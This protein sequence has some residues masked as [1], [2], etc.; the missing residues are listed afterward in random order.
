M[1]HWNYRIIETGSG[2][3]EI[4]EV[5]Y[6]EDGT[7][8]AISEEAEGVSGESLED[9][10][11]GLDYVSKAMNAPILKESEIVFVDP[12]GRNE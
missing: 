2:M 4:R 9:L 11:L 10:K 8:F 3:F 1:Q 7:I 12:V 5:Y 6:N